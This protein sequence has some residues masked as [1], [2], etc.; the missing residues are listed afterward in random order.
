MLGHGACGCAP[1]RRPRLLL[2]SLLLLWLFEME[3]V[4]SWW[5][6]GEWKQT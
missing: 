5:M 4:W 6:A 2:T 1:G 3:Q